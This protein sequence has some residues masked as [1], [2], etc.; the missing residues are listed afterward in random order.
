MSTPEP[1]AA[2]PRRVLV[3]EDEPKKKKPTKKATKKVKKKKGD[4]ADPV[5]APPGFLDFEVR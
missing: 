1:T 3:V 4:K 5:E 2:D